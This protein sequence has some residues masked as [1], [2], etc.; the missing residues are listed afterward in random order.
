MKKTILTVVLTTAFCVGLIG[1]SQPPIVAAPFQAQDQID[2]LVTR[3]RQWARDS[4]NLDNEGIALTASWN[5]ISGSIPASGGVTWSGS[6]TNLTKAQMTSV[7]TTIS[8]I[9]TTYASGNIT[10]VETFAKPKP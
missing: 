10:N 8:N 7:I 6:N 9:H 1:N 3:T 2:G 4:I 5:Q